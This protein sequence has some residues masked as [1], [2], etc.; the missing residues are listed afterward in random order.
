MDGEDEERIMNLEEEL[1]GPEIMNVVACE[2]LERV[3]RLET[4][5]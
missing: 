1:F 2:G 5:K 3:T 4:Y